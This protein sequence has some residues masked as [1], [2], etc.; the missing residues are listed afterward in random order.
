MCT[1]CLGLTV[2][3]VA[4]KL[5]ATII[6]SFQ[7]GRKLLLYAIIKTPAY[8]AIDDEMKKD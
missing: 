7:E 6:K 4:L 3:L 2:I 8:G 5:G 1:G